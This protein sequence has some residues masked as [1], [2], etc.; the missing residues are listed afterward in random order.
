MKRPTSNNDTTSQV[1]V[2]VMGNAT[3][4]ATPEKVEE[5]TENMT[6][7]TQD[8]AQKEEKAAKD[9]ATTAD[10]LTQPTKTVLEETEAEASPN[11]GRAQEEQHPSSEILI[12]QAVEG[13]AV[14]AQEEKEKVTAWLTG[15]LGEM[16]KGQISDETLKQLVHALHYDRDMAQAGHDGEVRGRNTRID[17]WFDQRRGVADIHNLGNAA[18]PSR[19]SPPLS[20]IGGLTAA[21][22]SSIWE[23]GHE[24][25]VRH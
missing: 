15:I 16:D 14:V 23:R 8:M 4:I 2:K 12:R 3:S 13:S 22:R 1:D 7:P 25:R 11:P 17:E 5:P 6:E 10:T 19:P 20:V 18:T 21:D 24:K 9:E